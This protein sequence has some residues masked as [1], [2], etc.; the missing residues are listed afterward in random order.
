MICFSP[1]Q[2][3]LLSKPPPAMMSRATRSKS[4]ALQS[5]TRT[6]GLPGPAQIAR[7][8]VFIAASTTPGPPVMQSR[9]TSSCVQ[10][11]LNESI[12]GFS[13]VQSRLEI[14]V[15]ALIASLNSSIASA[16]TAAPPG[17][18]LN[19]MELPAATM[20]TM[21]PAIV[22]TECVNG[23]TPTI[24]PQ[25]AASSIVIPKSPLMPCGVRYSGPSTFCTP[26]SFAGLCARRP[27]LVSLNSICPQRS[28]LSTHIFLT[29]STICLRAAQPLFWSCSKPLRAAATA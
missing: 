21:L 18:G 17:C 27:I 20:L 5:S 7:L 16:A 3:K 10:S 24:T 8:P 29:R 25:G 9:L 4:S 22:G 11:A 19:T 15:S 14:P 1:M 26:C 6:G 12:E 28:A 13:I 2:S 23:V